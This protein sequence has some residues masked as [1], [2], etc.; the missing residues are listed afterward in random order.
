[1]HIMPFG[2]VDGVPLDQVKAS[3]LII[4]SQA[5]WRLPSEPSQSV[6]SSPDKNTRYT[7]IWRGQR[8]Q[9]NHTKEEHYKLC[10]V[11]LPF[12]IYPIS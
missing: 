6:A 4:L 5:I 7:F 9:L 12:F 2:K 8:L 10:A 1:M 3:N 11:L